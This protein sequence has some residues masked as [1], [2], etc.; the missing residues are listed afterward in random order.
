[1]ENQ[2]FATIHFDGVILESTIGCIFETHQKIE[3][4]IPVI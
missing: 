4:F 3:I 2:F 1:M